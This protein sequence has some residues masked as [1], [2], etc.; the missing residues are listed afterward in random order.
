ML[1]LFVLCSLAQV[2]RFFVGNRQRCR[3]QKGRKN[4]DGRVPLHQLV[5]DEFSVCPDITCAACVSVSVCVKPPTAF[6]CIQLL[7]CEAVMVVGCDDKTCRQTQGLLN[8]R[9]SDIR[10]PSGVCS[11]ARTY[12]RLVDPEVGG[13]G[14]LWIVSD[15]PLR[16]EN[17][18][19][20]HLHG[21]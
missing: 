20:C 1:T 3:L 6:F 15:F 4:L 2:A 5:Q 8:Q 7:C 10:A 14:Q 13:S 11:P 21:A 19:K 17:R 9:T 12:S 16:L 18:T